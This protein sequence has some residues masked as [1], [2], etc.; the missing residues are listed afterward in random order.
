MPFFVS[1]FFHDS[2]GI[3]FLVFL[4]SFLVAKDT[5]NHE[6]MTQ[7]SCWQKCRLRQ[8]FCSIS[9][10]VNTGQ[11]FQICSIPDNVNTEQGFLC[12]IPDNI[13]ANAVQGFQSC[14]IP[15]NVNTV[16]GF[17]IWRSHPDIFFHWK[18]L[19][20]WLF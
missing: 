3:C 4:L 13:N 19:H 10:N 2:N 5:K 1:V 6:W 7:Y 17:Q 20:S 16:Q 12:S 9:D 15:D 14:S 8:S 11:G 18:S